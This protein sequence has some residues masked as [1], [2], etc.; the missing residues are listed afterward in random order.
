M[1]GISLAHFSGQGETEGK[2]EMLEDE[3][4]SLLV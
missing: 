1:E 4:C 2:G 3:R